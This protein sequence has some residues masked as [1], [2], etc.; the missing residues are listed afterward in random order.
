[1]VKIWMKY[2][3]YK[4]ETSIQMEAMNIM[5]ET[6]LS[7]FKG[8]RLQVW[9]EE[10]FPLLEEVLNESQIQITFV[11]MRADYEDVVAIR[12]VFCSEHSDMMIELEHVPVQEASDKFT[13]LEDLVDMMQEGPFEAL[14]DPKIR[15][16]F[17]KALNSE[18]EIA[19][20][21]TMSSGKSTL[22]NSFLGRDLM[23]S[24]N[25]ACTA[26]IS[27]IR[28]NDSIENFSAVA[29][30]QNHIPF[31]SIEDATVEDFE[32]FN[33][34]PK[35]ALV[36]IEGN[37]PS[38]ASGKMNLVLVDTPGP[39]NSMDGTHREHTFTVIKSD[40]KPMVLYVLNATQLRTDDDFTLLK[41]VA[42]A[43]AVGGKQS[44]DRFIFAVNKADC[45]DPEKNEHLSDAIENVRT[46]LEQH[47]IKNPNI[48]PV[49]AQT[50]KVIRKA[51]NN[52]DL[53]RHERQS[54]QG[55]DLFLEEESMHLNEY[56]PL[57]PSL[58]DNISRKIE[59]A[60]ANGDE[61]TEALYYSGVPS[62]ESA[63]NEYLDKYALTSKITNA[64]N[65]FKRIV[66]REQFMQ[67]LQEELASNEEERKNVHA[68]MEKIEAQLVKGNQAQEFKKKI[69]KLDFNVGEYFEEI[70]EKVFGEKINELFEKMRD[71]RIRKTEADILLYK[72]KKDLVILQDDAMTD[73]Q[74]IIDTT[75][76]KKAEQYLKEYQK[77]IEGIMDFKVN[78][79]NTG[80]WEK[81][82][83]ADIPDI[84]NLL[85]DFAYSE[86]EV[87]GVRSVRNEKKKWYKPW[88][89]FMSR[90][91]DEDVYGDVEYVNLQEVRE[92]F[93]EPVVD[94]LR[95][96][97][98]NAQ[99]FMKGEL[100]SLQTFFI[101]EI[102]RL[103]EVMKKRVLEIKE[104]AENRS[105]LEE[106][107]RQK[108]NQKEWLEQFVLKLDSVLELEE[109]VG[110]TQ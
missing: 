45:F 94:S 83:T 44:K 65:T 73:L 15:H 57:S 97:F 25:E 79:I 43:M 19:V 14:R 50:A 110:V 29:Y 49:S 18:F 39:N 38:I 5:E 35:I 40:D 63:I 52:Y 102:D 99:E 56:A 93:L 89:Y 101:N 11:G 2:N 6:K 88:T 46:Y 71:D 80:N 21:A 69:M 67:N 75:S 76:R 37:I 53:T 90:T 26:K 13:E 74:I 55:I 10:L 66:E 91:I 59:V 31:K 48:Y 77:Y 47:G 27:R 36:E 33:D 100:A 58:K 95:D 60:R 1:M 17:D 108:Q 103:D 54:L 105:E 96:N 30:D 7:K 68:A 82:I 106:E 16:N 84:D 61:Q 107:L 8:D 104:L 109:R 20:I 81:A 70:N 64:V 12:N 87:V 62:V 72:M 92:E 23:P 42:E 41:T 22:I 78:S 3:P 24:K 51:Q 4:V 98:A 9:I 28:N 32:D 34:D 85:N 86:R